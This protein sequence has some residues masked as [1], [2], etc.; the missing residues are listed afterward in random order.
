MERERNHWINESLDIDVPRFWL[1]HL[2]NRALD[3]KN[4]GSRRRRFLRSDAV[5][6]HGGEFFLAEDMKRH[7]SLFI[8]SESP[9]GELIA[10]TQLTPERAHARIYQWSIRFQTV[11]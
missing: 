7:L 9:M 4:S 3:A 10:D 6:F 2:V 5:C 1:V 11:F 8:P